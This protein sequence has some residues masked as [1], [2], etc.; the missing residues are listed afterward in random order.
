MEMTYDWIVFS[1]EEFKQKVREAISCNE[2]LE[3]TWNNMVLISFNHET[4]CAT[5]KPLSATSPFHYKIIP[6]MISYKAV[7]SI[8]DNNFDNITD[9]DIILLDE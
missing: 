4:Q 6:K 8:M 1:S 5:V 2:N 3:L 7:I 9:S